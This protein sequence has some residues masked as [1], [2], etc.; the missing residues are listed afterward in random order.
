AVMVNGP[1]P[2]PAGITKAMLAPVKLATGAEIVPPLW[3]LSVTWGLP[4]PEVK[5]LPLTVMSDPTDAD[6]GLKS[7][8]AGP[9]LTVMDCELRFPATSTA[10][11][12]MVF[13]PGP[14][15]T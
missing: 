15:L 6:L 8:I 14:R 11:T 13:D 3:L 4:E 12:V 10:S 9:R 1:L 7:V 2:A 5:P